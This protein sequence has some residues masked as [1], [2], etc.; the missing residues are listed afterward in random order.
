MDSRRYFSRESTTTCPESPA[1]AASNGFL[2][3]F[4]NDYSNV[5]CLLL[6]A[7]LVASPLA[8]HEPARFTCCVSE[9]LLIFAG[10]AVPCRARHDQDIWGHAVLGQRVIA[11]NGIIFGY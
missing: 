5:L 11:S 7:L 9:G 3:D 10:K 6:G 8:A 2:F 1:T 4:Y